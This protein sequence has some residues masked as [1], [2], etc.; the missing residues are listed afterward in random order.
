M[1]PRDNSA[2][3]IF[4]ES[5]PFTNYGENYNKGYE[6]EATFRNTIGDFEYRLYAQLT[7][8]VNEIVLTDEPV[9]L[10]PNLR[11]TGQ[12]IDQYFGYQVIG[13][14]QSLDDIA[15][16]PASKV[17]G[18][19]IPGDFKYA[20]INGDNVIND[21]DRVPIG[22]T[23]VPRNVFGIEPSIS[24]KGIGLSA[25]IQGVSKVSSNLIFDGNGRNQYYSRMLDRWTPENAVN[26]NWPAMRPGSLGGNPSYNVNSFLLQDA[27][28]VR[29]RNIEL[30][31]QFPAAIMDK[32][33]L[34]SLRLFV[35]GQN[36]LTWT[37]L[38]GLDPESNISRTYNRQFFSNPTYTYPVTK[39]YNFGLN[40][41]F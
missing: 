34:G 16:S 24:Y 12:S 7:H 26:A 18:P 21:Q 27:S 33:K 3:D 11:R 2:P 20:D 6:I 19:V 39:V 22:Y 8:A 41:Q 38:I 10:A 29:L 17:S 37:K 15:A 40:V 4:G 30:S 32:L 28:Y 25:L 5:L 1:L 31:Y 23:D 36:L 9:N 35:N 14:Y 13:F